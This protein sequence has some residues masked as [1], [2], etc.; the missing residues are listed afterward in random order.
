[1]LKQILRSSFFLV[2][3][4]SLPFFSPITL[5][6][7][8]SAS[9]SAT[10]TSS[11]VI[12]LPATPL[13]L[14][15]TPVTVNIVADPGQTVSIPFKVRNNGVSTEKLQVTLGTFIADET[16][17]RPKLLD[18]KPEDTYMQWL[19]VDQPYFELAGGEWKTIN[20]TF[21]PPTEAA[22]SYFYTVKIGR[23][24]TQAEPGKT[25]IQGAPALLVLANVTSPNA[26]KELQ[27]STFRTSKTILEHLPQTFEFT[28]TNTGNVHI[29]PN[30]TLFIDGEGKKDLAVL[31]AN[32]GNNA[33]L[34]GSTRVY[35]V[36]WDDSTKEDTN[37]GPFDWNFGQGSHLRWGKYTAHMLLVYDN[38][39]RDV[40]IESFVS[41]WVIPWRIFA[42]RLAV[43]IVPAILVY[44]LMK[45]QS[46]R[47]QSKDHHE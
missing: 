27:L 22:L 45:W 6:N 16:G 39:E 44:L 38:G 14:T 3:S 43:P 26:K 4:L 37:N 19:T 18:P 36:Q 8:Q 35:S 30:G 42:L 11:P 46:R 31:P 12:E 32:A 25:V 34:P 23:S 17:Q 47:K 29:I 40:P 20:L 21:A 9:E 2:A 5:A 13:N 10:P 1:M 7:A 33:V 41:F 15:L 24:Q 28:V